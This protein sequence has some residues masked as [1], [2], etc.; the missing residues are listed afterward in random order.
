MN[1]NHQ[2]GLSLLEILVA[3]TIFVAL[4]TVVSA[5]MTGA[6]NLNNQSQKQLSTSSRAQQVMESIRGNW[7]LPP[8]SGSIRS[9]Y[10]DRACAPASL[11]SLN[12]VTAKYINLDSR[13][14]PITSAGASASNPTSSNITISTNCLA[15]PVV[16]LSSGLP[17]PMRRII[18]ST[19]TSNQDVTLTLDV[20]RP[21]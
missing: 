3:V 20:L 18:V 14:Q 13:A 16:Q 2:S 11:V 10:Y 5:T 9:D 6:L 15:Q 19:G 17:Y 7:N 4:F 1:Q 8:A 12:G 21:Q